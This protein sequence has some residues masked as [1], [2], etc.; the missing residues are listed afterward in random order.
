MVATAVGLMGGI[1]MSNEQIFFDTLYYANRLKAVGV[2]EKQAEVQAE[3]MAET[4]NNNLATKRDIKELEVK[5]ETIDLKI[6]TLRKDVR[7]DMKVLGAAILLGV[8]IVG[9]LVQTHH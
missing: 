2:P 5:I 1:S 7:S 8:T 9:V 6:E 4:I 3:I